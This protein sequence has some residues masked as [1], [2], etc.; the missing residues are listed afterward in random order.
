MTRI[1]LIFLILFN[2]FFSFSQNEEYFK[3]TIKILSAN[4]KHGRGYIKHGDKKASKFIEKEFEKF[5]LKKLK[6]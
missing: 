6:Y 4:D 5:G 3:N 2:A 1:T